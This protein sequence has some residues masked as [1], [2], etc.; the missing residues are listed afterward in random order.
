MKAEHRAYK[1]NLDEI[2]NLYASD[3]SVGCYMEQ[4]PYH[5][6]RP[7]HET[8]RRAPAWPAKASKSSVP[9]LRCS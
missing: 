8:P 6:V 5:A 2:S 1:L 4:M 3:K 7:K 9:R